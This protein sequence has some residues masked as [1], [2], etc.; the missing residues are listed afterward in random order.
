MGIPCWSTPDGC[1]EEGGLDPGD[2]ERA[3]DSLATLASPVRLSVLAALDREGPLS[4][5]ALRA[6]AGV[7][8]KGRFNYHLRRLD[9]LVAAEDGT[10]RLS[11]RGERVVR[12]LDDDALSPAE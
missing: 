12:A 8:D 6:A 7:E 3:A 4:Y 10:Y 2:V 11:E 5:T 9:G 1:G